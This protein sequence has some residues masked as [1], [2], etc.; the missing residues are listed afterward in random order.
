M[1]RGRRQS[2]RDL[3]VIVTPKWQKTNNSEHLD[4]FRTVLAQPGSR[5]G[6]TAS[7]KVGG[8]VVRNQFKRRVREWFRGR[9]I[10]IDRDLDLVVI[11]KRSAA[12]LS[13]EELDVHLSR[14][15][16]LNPPSES[17]RPAT[18]LQ[19]IIGDP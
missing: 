4:G 1:R 14:L 10:D 6:I 5:L 16:G 12:A 9:R 17:R 2:D 18:S 19:P 8:A 3:I 15:L 7:R 11:A 13:L